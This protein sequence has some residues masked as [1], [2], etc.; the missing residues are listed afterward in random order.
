MAAHDNDLFSLVRHNRYKAVCDLVEQ[1]SRA[2][3]FN[4]DQRDSFGNT[5]LLTSCQ[6]GLKGMAKLMLRHGADIDATN[7]KGN[8]ALHFCALFGYYHTLG[9]YLISKGCDTA[10]VNADGLVAEDLHEKRQLSLGLPSDKHPDGKDDGGHEGASGEVPLPSIGN[11][12]P[13][14]SSVSPAI[15]MGSATSLIVLAK[16]KVRRPLPGETRQLKQWEQESGPIRLKK[17]TQYRPPPKPHGS[18]SAPDLNAIRSPVHGSGRDHLGY[19]KHL[20]KTSDNSNLEESSENYD[21]DFDY[22][23]EGACDWY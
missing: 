12:A 17:A 18:C 20:E 23:E 5:L 16:S 15:S 19:D 21:D 7:D 14:E 10:L 9:K 13:N 1:A 8:S 3:G 2:G 6:N 4:P 22:G 11:G